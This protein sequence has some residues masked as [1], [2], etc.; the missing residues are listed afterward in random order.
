MQLTRIS[1]LLIFVQLLLRTIA[2]G[3]SKF[4]TRM[5]I[6]SSLDP[7]RWRI[8]RGFTIQFSLSVLPVGTLP[9]VPQRDES[10][11]DDNSNSN[12]AIV[13]GQRTSN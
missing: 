13:E 6:P 9:A 12:E 4:W 10:R 1:S 8:G 3:K 5:S 2:L 7:R 11:A